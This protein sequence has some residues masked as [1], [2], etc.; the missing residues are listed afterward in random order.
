LPEV[1]QRISPLLKSSGGGRGWLRLTR[2]GNVKQLKA[3]ADFILR[4]GYTPRDL[5]RSGDCIIFTHARRKYV[6][7]PHG[8]IESH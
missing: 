3:L 2:K 5:R 7:F 8:E 1:F 6:V 4:I